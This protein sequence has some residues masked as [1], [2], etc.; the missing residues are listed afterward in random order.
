MTEAMAVEKLIA[1]LRAVKVKL[2]IEEGKLKFSAPPGVMTDQLRT[3]LSLSKSALIAWLEQTVPVAQHKAPP[4][5]SLERR[6]E[7]VLSFGQERLWFLYE[8]DPES[9]AYNISSV[10]RVAGS[11]DHASLRASFAEI[12]T[13]H[14]VLRTTISADGGRPYAVIARTP[15]MELPLVDLRDIEASRREEVVRQLVDRETRRPFD[16]SRGPVLRTG[17]LRTQDDEHVLLITLHHAFCDGWSLGVLYRELA[18]FYEAGCSGRPARLA[19]LPI[20]YADY[21]LWQRKRLDEGG[22][23]SQLSYWKARLAGAPSS[24][25][26]P[27]DRPRPAVQSFAGARQEF[28][29][30]KGLAESLAEVSRRQGVTLFMTLMAAFQTLLYRYTG[31]SD[32]VVGSPIAGRTR[33]E[34]E[35]LIGLFMNTVVFR[36]EMSGTLKFS[37]LLAQVRQ[38]ALEAYAHQD[39]SFEK[40]VEELQ[41]ERDLS[42]TPLFQ[43]MFVLQNVPAD[44]VEFADLRLKPLESEFRTSKFDLTL[45]MQE[46]GRG[47]SGSFEY[48]SDLFDSETITRLQGHFEVLLTGIVANPEQQLSALPLLTEPE[49]RQLLAEWNGTDAAYPAAMCLHEQFEA[50]VQRTPDQVA[51]VFDDEQLT[52]RAL[53]ARA[54]QL[55][56]HLTERGVGPD[57]LVG[58]CMERSLELIV[59]LLGVLKAGGAYVPLDPEYPPERLALI[60]ADA[61]LS[62]LLTQDRLIERLGEIRVPVVRIDGDWPAIQ[63]ERVEAALSP[64]DSENLAYV[65]FTSG[66]TGRPKGVQIQHRSV[67]NFIETIQRTPGLTT[68]DAFVSVTTISF[69]ISVLEL[70]VPL[71]TGARLIIAAPDTVRDGT[72]LAR[73]ATRSAATIMQGTPATWRLLLEAGWHGTADFKILIGGQALGRD[74]ATEL[75][76]GDTQVWNMYGPTETTIWSTVD[77]VHP[78]PDAITIGRP[79]ANTQVFVLDRASNPLPAG[80]PGELFIGGDGLSRGYR[81]RP[82]LTSTSFVPSPFATGRRLYRTGDRVRYRSDGRVEFL[83]RIDHQVKIRGFRIELGEIETTLERHPAIRQAFATVRQDK[84]GTERLCAYILPDEQG[85]PAALELRQFVAGKLP[86]YMVP[87]SFTTLKTIPLTPNGKVDRRALPA[88]D[89]SSVES[90]DAAARSPHEEIISAIWCDV[91]GIERVG[92]H[93]NFFHVGGHSLLATQVIA[94]INAAFGVELGLRQLFEDPTVVDL[95]RHVGTAISKGDN[96]RSQSL[97]RLQKDEIRAL[98]FAQE[99]LWFLDQLEPNSSAY[100]ISS[101]VGLSGRLNVEALEQAFKEIVRRHETL[102]TTFSVVNEQP[103]QVIADASALSFQRVDLR[104]LG[105]RDRLLQSKLLSDQEADR[106]FDLSRGPLLRATLIQLADEEFGVFLTVHH[107]VWDDWSLAVLVKE[108][109]TLYQLFSQG[110]S[111][112]MPDL[113]IQ[114]ADYAAWQRKWLDGGRLQIQ[115]AYWRE[116]LEG[117]PTS[118]SL[119]TDRPRPVVQTFR[120]ASEAFHLSQEVSGALRDLSRRQGSTLFMT[121][122]AA[123]YT[124]LYRC[125]GQQ[126]ILVGTPIAGRTR[127]EAEGLIG[128]FAN[129]LVMRADMHGNL[130]FDELLAQVRE[131]ALGAYTHQDLPF[132]KVVEEL[133]VPRDLS[134]TPLFQVMFVLQNAQAEELKLP[135]VTFKPLESERTTAKFDLTVSLS[136]TS[137]GLYGAFEYNTDLFDRETVVRMSGHLGRLLE[138]ISTNP[139]QRLSEL[140]LLSDAERDRVLV[141]WNDTATEYPRDASIQEVFEGQVRRTPDAV[142]VVA[143]DEQLTYAELNRQANQLAEHLAGLGVGAETA[144][145][146]YM[147]RTPDIVIAQLGVLKCGAVYV[148]LDPEYPHRRLRFIAE[149]ARIAVLV[150]MEAPLESFVGEGVR[151]IAL[152]SARA[153]LARQASTNPVARSVSDSL[154]YVVYT[155]GSTGIPK[156]VEVPHR[157]VLRL[158]FGVKYARID[159]DVVIPHLSSPTFDASTFE[160]WAPLLHGGRCVLYP[161]RVPT[162]RTLSAAIQQH[163]LTTMWLTAALFNTVVDEDPRLLTGLDQLLIG[164]EALSLS[165]VRRALATLPS[166]TIINGY[167]PTESTT[168][169][170]CYPIPVALGADRMSVPIGP[171]IGNTTVYVLDEH[172]RPVPQGVSGEVHIGGAGLARGYLGRAGLTAERFVPDPYDA[173]PGQRAYRTG[174]LARHLD[175]GAVEFQGRLDHQVKI[176]GFRIEVGEIEA[177]L[178][179]HPDVRETVVLARETSAGEKRLVAYLTTDRQTPLTTKE[180]RSFLGNDLPEYMLPAAFVTLESFPLTPNRKIDRRALP[181]PEAATHDLDETYVAPSTPQEEILA[182]MWSQLLGVARIGV[183]DNFFEQGGHSLL[184]TQLVSRVREAFTVDLPVRAI[185]EHPTVAD[186]ALA[187]TDAG[188]GESGVSLPPVV[189]GSRAG[190]MPLSY[191]QQRLWLLDRMEPGNPNYNFP[192][193]LR[194]SGRLNVQALNQGVTEIVAR[195]DILRATFS[196]HD[197]TP[198]QTIVPPRPAPLPVVDLSSLPSEEGEKAISRLAEAEAQRPFNLAGEQPLLRLTLLHLGEQDNVILFSMHHIACDGWSIGVFVR[199]LSETYQAFSTGECSGLAELPLQYSDFAEWQRQSLQ[200]DALEF[201][202]DYWRRRLGGRLPV[203]NLP[204]GQE[205][206]AMPTNDAKSVA[207]TVPAPVTTQIRQLCR[208]EKTTLFMTLLAAFQALLHQHTGDE[209]IVVGTDL[210]GRHDVKLESLIGFFVNLLVMRTD[211]SGNPSFRQLLHRV[212]ETALGAYAH[213]DVPFVKLV[214]ELQPQRHVSNTPLFQV[215]FVLQNTPVQALELPGLTFKRIKAESGKAKFDLAVFVA[216]SGDQLSAEWVYNTD[217]YTASQI[218][219]MAQHYESLLRHVVAEPNIRLKK[220]AF[221][222]HYNQASDPTDKKVRRDS[223]IAKLKRARQLHTETGSELADHLRH[224]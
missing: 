197:G 1:T 205:R 18:E 6:D 222:T 76:R 137:R 46:T 123:F 32:V 171:P 166:T 65:T 143:G 130:R 39:L 22:L 174:D 74:L 53:N 117:A 97:V 28:V 146:V 140:P 168:F 52:Y 169:T 114:Y 210:A 165:H 8:L 124:L 172:M 148:P 42:R 178:S 154:A 132:E 102:R 141:E 90:N 213:Q 110:R 151:V 216:E 26:L 3:E 208:Q 82:E 113:S 20:Q 131:A 49:W 36:A 186:L 162:P 138:G 7:L 2:W 206:P 14:E 99:R 221:Q 24:I 87:S 181:E 139:K 107:V 98:S 176:R 194:L 150:T 95:A 37:E 80:V 16:L 119:R 55:A 121:L 217:L 108:L 187:I 85:A 23:Q 203:L 177:A 118:L 5:P 47:L 54:N 35:E 220:I 179:K 196:D 134:R 50:Q 201:Q 158:L 144:V 160:V 56:R 96:S 209:D 43:V 188:R 9:P 69:D 70:F 122:L 200:G 215:L 94:R 12:V 60:I 185:F 163:G 13:R 126:Q 173:V 91:L 84:S 214:E 155:S 25:E 193:G 224:E 103:I 21:A 106:P 66:S 161:E 11:I 190:A 147:E 29:L 199:E 211:L 40:L 112:S 62:A 111:S 48:N 61:K 116:R 19:A 83:G 189:R 57:R 223:K 33:S 164:G 15:A 101:A 142:A 128:F 207:M 100:N 120:G 104:A 68:N 30:S 75:L 145:G 27:T 191:A 195:H 204:R 105:D 81:E 58:I 182:E 10:T 78:A 63:R 71:L 202:L 183:H 88:P 180:L 184:A 175:D 170:C 4:I 198:V 51:V 41:P 92:I 34:V 31:Q 153:A 67:V 135:D 86:E 129:T 115:R 59:G 38:R 45:E 159:D 109:S 44:V 127:E 167:G 149:D 157:G 89:Y 64:V 218:G 156:G 133:E 219:E 79:I 212:R 125:T 136:E 17:L 73:L 77:R 93:D 152:N 192:A 72:Q